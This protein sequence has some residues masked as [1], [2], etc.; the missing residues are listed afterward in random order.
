MKNECKVLVKESK[1]KRP[2]GSKYCW[3][4]K[5]VRHLQERGMRGWNELIL[6]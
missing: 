5:T 1:G 6:L 4:D 3:D 2:C